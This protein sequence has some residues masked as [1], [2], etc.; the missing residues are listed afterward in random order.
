MLLVCLTVAVIRPWVSTR[1]SS[2]VPPSSDTDYRDYKVRSVVDV[3]GVFRDFQPRTAT[4]GHPDFGLLAPGGGGI[5]FRVAAD[6]LDDASRPQLASTGRKRTRDWLDASSRPVCPTRPY[7]DARP[8]DAAGSMS[9]AAGDVVTSSSTFAQWF[10]DGLPARAYAATPFTLTQDGSHYVFDGSFDAIRTGTPDY[11]YTYELDTF[12]IFERS[13][14]FYLSLATTCDA[15]AFIDDKLVIDAG[16]GVGIV[17]PTLA[18]EET[19]SMAN[20]SRIV[21]GAGGSI[22][23]NST[24]NGAINLANSASVQGDV[25]VGPGGNSNSGIRSVRSDSIVG[26]RGV[27]AERVPIAIVSVPSD[28][29]V[30][31]P[32]LVVDGATVTWDHDL[33][34]SALTI[35]NHANITVRGTVR[36][37]V[38]KAIT[39]ETSSVI[40]IPSGARLEMYAMED[41]TIRSSSQVNVVSG[42]PEGLLIA[43]MGAGKK[44]VVDN[45]TVVGGSLVAPSG[46]V[47]LSN[48]STVYGTITARAA[49]LGNNCTLSASGPDGTAGGGTGATAA[50]RI[51]LDRLAWLAHG[52]THR[53]RMFFANRTGTPSHATI[54]T[55]ITTLNLARA[56]IE[57]EPGAD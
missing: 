52:E 1:S 25:L 45:L 36:V 49:A 41:V 48:R 32:A 4:G 20:S 11:S 3:R 53:L 55:N 30:S 43:C 16:K 6:Q 38:D 13:A 23:T 34:V 10:R 35:T 5:Y 24:A 44:I 51:D 46:A 27:L 39:I 50:Q 22:T 33:H 57:A 8:G 15:W 7:I 56:P 26:A 42:D 21:A 47:E 40:T 29:P 2:A 54:R 18:V 17:R 28:M 37:L 19:I 31:Q 9:T 12:F 14:S